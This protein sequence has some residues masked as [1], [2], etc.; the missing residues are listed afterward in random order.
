MNQKH[1]SIPSPSISR[2]PSTLLSLYPKS[3]IWYLS[4]LIYSPSQSH[5]TSAGSQSST[6]SPRHSARCSCASTLCADRLP[7][8]PPYLCYSS[9][10]SLLSTSTPL[11][12]PPSISAI[13][14]NPTPSS[15][16]CSSRLFY[17]Y[18]ASTRNLMES[19]Q[20]LSRFLCSLF[21]NSTMNPYVCL[22]ELSAMSLLSC[23]WLSDS[24]VWKVCLQ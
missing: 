13:W 16:T 15:P 5:S 9:L 10:S 2:N 4:D 18:Y 24:D 12:F 19:I 22:H 20:L 8:P 11:W 14:Y 6:T 23:N 17:L 21:L 1:H 3:M 7:P